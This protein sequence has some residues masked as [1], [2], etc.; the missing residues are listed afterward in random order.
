MTTATFNHGRPTAG[1][2]ADANRTELRNRAQVRGWL[3]LMIL[4]F[5]A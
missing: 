4:I 1:V 3:Y 5:P 2:H